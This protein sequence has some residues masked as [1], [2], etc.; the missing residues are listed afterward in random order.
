MI[1]ELNDEEMDRLNRA[2]VVFLGLATSL[3]DD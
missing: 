1:G 3:D 2:V